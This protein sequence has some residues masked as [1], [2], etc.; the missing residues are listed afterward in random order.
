MHGVL[1]VRELETQ[2]GGCMLNS[3]L[4]HGHITS[5]GKLFTYVVPLWTN[6]IICYFPK[7]ATAPWLG[8]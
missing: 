5:L 6:S 3:Q 8:S 2:S 7:A 4:L 1:L